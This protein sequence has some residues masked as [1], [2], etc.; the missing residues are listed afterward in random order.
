MEKPVHIRDPIH[1][2]ITL[3]DTEFALVNTRAFQRLRHIRQLGLT[4]QVFPG[5][6]HTRFSHSLGVMHLAERM[7]ERLFA[8]PSAR[9]LSAE[10][11]TRLVRLM[12]LAALL[13][14]L[15]HPPFSHALEDLFEPGIGHEAMARDIVLNT[16]IADL[17]AATGKPWG[18]GPEEVTA[19]MAGSPAPGLEF[20][21][22]VLSSELDIDKMDYLLRDSLYCGV[23]YGTFDLERLLYTA[24][25]VQ[26]PGGP[27]LGVH[28]SGIHA[29]EAFVL[30]RYYMFAQV[31]FN[32]TSKV[33]ELHLKRF[34]NALDLRWAR[35][36]DRFLE[37]DDVFVY[38]LL[39]AHADHPD[40][41]AILYRRHYPLLY[42]TEESLS[43]E[44]ERRF[45]K[46]VGTLQEEHPDWP[47][48]VS[49]ASK[50]PHRFADSRILVADDAG[51][52]AEVVQV[53]SFIA[54]LKRI[55]QFR[56]YGPE[57]LAAEVKATL[58]RQWKKG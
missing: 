40:A 18:V 23:R 9:A 30:A 58:D 39:K 11:K 36:V 56:I 37:Q 46:L 15:G 34:F 16:E 41:Q 52:A 33:L 4:D 28:E 1:G 51:A 43:R 45:A 53:S 22:T 54:H 26:A 14:D 5:A 48:F 55:N 29:L 20:L 2:Y 49:L 6:T 35:S 57:N 10:E 31:Y 50:D 44:Q 32:V 8:Q 24:V 12:R 19:L 27:R 13:H 17:L 3:N 42:E 25:L 47:C 7:L 21:S 38:T